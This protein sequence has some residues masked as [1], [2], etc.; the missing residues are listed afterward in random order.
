MFGNSSRRLGWFAAHQRQPSWGLGSVRSV[1]IVSKVATREE[2]KVGILT[3]PVEVDAIK[4]VLVVD[5]L[6]VGDEGA[7]GRFGSYAGAEV[8]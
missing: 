8:S 2:L 7:P 4:L 6:N 3:L 1:D 5:F